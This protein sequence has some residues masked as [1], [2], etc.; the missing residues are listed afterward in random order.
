M[1]TERENLN[2]MKGV[3][4]YSWFKPAFLAAQNIDDEKKDRPVHEPGRDAEEWGT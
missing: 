2:V 1:K 4:E 3:R